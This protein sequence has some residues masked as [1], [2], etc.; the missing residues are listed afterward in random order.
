[1]YKEKNPYRAKISFWL[2]TFLVLS[3]M[4]LPWYEA[5]HIGWQWSKFE[6]VAKC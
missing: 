4:C 5:S 6:Y 3:Y 2:S 1:M